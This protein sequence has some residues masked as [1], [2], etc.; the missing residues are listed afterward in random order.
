MPSE[1]EPQLKALF[2]HYGAF[3]ESTAAPFFDSL[4]STA[5]LDKKT[6]ELVVVALLTLRGWETGV[7]THVRLALDAGATAQEI[8]GAILITLGVGG[9]TAAASGL[10]FAEPILVEWTKEAGTPRRG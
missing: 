6:Q 7:R 4:Y 8:R 10:A 9:V 2:D 3:W 1:P 5:G